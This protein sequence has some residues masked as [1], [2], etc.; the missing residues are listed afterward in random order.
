MAVYRKHKKKK[1]S[2]GIWAVAL[3]FALVLIAGALLVKKGRPD[4][5]GPGESLGQDEIPMP[6]KT[7]ALSIVPN[8]GWVNDP[9]DH[10]IRQCS[11]ST[12]T[13]SYYLHWKADASRDVYYVDLETMQGRTACP[14]PDC[15]HQ[16]GSC[17]AL[18]SAG[19][20]LDNLIVINDQLYAVQR[21]AVRK[22]GPQ[23]ARLNEDGSICEIV[24]ELPI[25]TE[26][27]IDWQNENIGFFTDGD[28]VILAC[29]KLM[30]RRIRLKMRRS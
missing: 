22:H 18:H 13:K 7:N 12:E 15:S 17:P 27:L 30:R 26:I 2:A 1:S 20:D 3:L 21:H 14:K 8:T 19:F 24:A 16:D 4:K 11:S 28:S 10:N 5:T 9:G 23:I 29:V 6:E 25:G